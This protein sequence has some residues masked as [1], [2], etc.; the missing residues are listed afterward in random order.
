[1]LNGKPR[2]IVVLGAGFGGLALASELNDV[3]ARGEAVVTLVDRTT[4]FNMGFSLQWVLT[5]RRRP[6]EGMRPYASML[7]E[8]VRFVHDE[9]VAIDTGARRVHT[10]TR[11][12]PYDDLVIATG[13]EMDPGRIPG[14]AEA[15]HNLCSIDHVL[16][17]KGALA[18]VDSGAVVIAV[19]AT[20]F[21][22]PPAPYEYALLV[23]E[24]L[25]ERGVRDRVPLILTTPEPHPMPTA[26]PRIGATVAA[27]MADN[28]VELHVQHRIT[29]VD[30]AARRITYENGLELQYAVF[31]A[32]W[33]HRAPKAVRAAGLTNDMGFVP[34]KFGTFETATPNVYAVGDV[35][36]MR[37]P[38][39][40]PHP[41]S[42]MF[43]EAQ[44]TIVGRNLA[45]Q[46]TGSPQVAYP[47]KG[48]CFFEMGSDMATAVEADLLPLD[49]PKM[50][51]QPPSAEGLE[52]K[53]EFEVDCFTR[54]F[55]G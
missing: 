51:M 47:G 55:G 3:A 27:W 36:A 53:A 42:G 11:D 12:L 8:H 32:M 26:G 46:I 38:S 37:L 52:L 16:Q 22:C 7:A 33:P 24:M 10:R 50:T 2:H 54:W 45:A 31:G 43:A 41:K 5:G 4:H 39:D 25:R 40:K 29:S 21:K 34:V 14:L 17:L 18:E 20:P 6:D 9:I 19:S 15:S 23:D 48:A 44:A 28:G 13:A 49:G 30:P 1:M 35:A